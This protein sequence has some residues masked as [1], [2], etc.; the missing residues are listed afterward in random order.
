MVPFQGGQALLLCLD[1]F[2]TS[3]TGWCSVDGYDLTMCDNENDHMVEELPNGNPSERTF[4]YAPRLI[5]NAIKAIQ[6]QT[7]LK[8]DE[9]KA[10]QAL[11]EMIPI[12]QSVLRLYGPDLA[13]VHVKESNETKK[14]YAMAMVKPRDARE[15]KKDLIVILAWLLFLCWQFWLSFGEERRS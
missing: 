5:A 7:G 2:P 8:V 3:N 4:K 15:K 6:D 1:Y 11:L 12:I 10:G 13:D 14:T 9:V